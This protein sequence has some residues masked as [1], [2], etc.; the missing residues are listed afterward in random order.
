MESSLELGGVAETERGR[1]GLKL[2]P[3]L[4][5]DKENEGVKGDGE[6]GYGVY[7]RGWFWCCDSRV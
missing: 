7:D 4:K 3:G 2:R 1:M 5:A 6:F